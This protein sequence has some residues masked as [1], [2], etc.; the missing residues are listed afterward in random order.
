[1]SLLKLDPQGELARMIEINLPHQSEEAVLHSKLIFDQLNLPCPSA[2]KPKDSSGL[3]KMIRGKKL[4]S[5]VP[6][7]QEKEWRGNVT[8]R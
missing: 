5:G 8:A 1:M 2:F 3:E 6:T 4:F 7:E